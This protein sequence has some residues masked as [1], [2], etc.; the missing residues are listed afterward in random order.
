MPRPIDRRLPDESKAA[1]NRA[2]RPALAM[3]VL[4]AMTIGAWPGLQAFAADPPEAARSV[5]GSVAPSTGMAPGPGPGAS[6]K[7]RTSPSSSSASSLSGSGQG[8]AR[9]ATLRKRYAESEACFARYRMKNRGLRPG[10]FQHCKQL[11]DPS[12]EC[13]SVV[14]P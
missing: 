12:M 8:D 7:K 2:R 6:P 13:G 14:V 11:I 9:C 1:V 10:A 5:P 4:V 3:M